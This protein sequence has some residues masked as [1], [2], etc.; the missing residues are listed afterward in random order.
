VLQGEACNTQTTCATGYCLD[1]LCV[2]P[3]ANGSSCTSA[4]QCRSLLCGDGQCQPRPSAC[5]QP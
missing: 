3:Q 5:M 4:A 2:A 1:G